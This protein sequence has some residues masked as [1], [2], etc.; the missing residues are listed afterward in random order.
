MTNRYTSEFL[1][2]L[3][4]KQYGMLT[5]KDINKD[6][7]LGTVCTVDCSCGRSKVYKVTVLLHG[8]AVSCGCKISQNIPKIG[9][10]FINKRGN[11][12]EVIEPRKWDDIIV[13]FDN[14]GTIKSFQAD[15]LKRKIFHDPYEKAYWGF[16]F[17]GD[18]NY[19][20]KNHKHIFNTWMHMVERCYDVNSKPYPVY[21]GAGVTVCE[22]WRNF[23]NFAAWFEQHKVEGW[24]L[25]KD[26]KNPNSKEYSPENCV[27]L[28]PEINSL[29]TGY[30]R[31]LKL[32]GTGRT[33][34]GTWY[35][36][37]TE[38]GKQTYLGVSDTWLDA[39]IKY[40]DRK[41]NNLIATLKR[42]PDLDKNVVNTA[43]EMTNIWYYLD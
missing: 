7:N 38:N 18:G 15:S 5:I 32:A 8:R 21:G 11:W 39:K 36:A 33:K 34:Q 27:F 26:F 35:A 24:H 9:D 3:I 28:P 17:T 2:G 23:Q 29:F 16:G 25:D 22:E 1:S 6:A 30:G 31:G 4:G 13:R 10:R 19:D 41:R 42:Y 37:V 40:L 20:G 12:C 43:L 14:T